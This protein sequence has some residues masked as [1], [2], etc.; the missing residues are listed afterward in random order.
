[1]DRCVLLTSTPSWVVLPRGDHSGCALVIARRG[2]T[3]RSGVDVNN[4]H[5]PMI[6][7]LNTSTTL[8]IN[9]KKFMTTILSTN[10]NY[11]WMSSWGSEWQGCNTSFHVLCV[12]DFKLCLW[13]YKPMPELMMTKIQGSISISRPSFQVW[14]FPLSKYESH[15]TIVTL[16]WKFLY[17]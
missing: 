5:L 15:E 8:T 7:P 13:C 9:A 3:T 14:G 2:E 6:N 1:M 4:T 11:I 10:C 12:I 16:W 17:W